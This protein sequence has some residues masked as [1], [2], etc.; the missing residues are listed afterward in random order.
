[1][2]I[3]SKNHANPSELQARLIEIAKYKS[4]LKKRSLKFHVINKQMK[5]KLTTSPIKSS[6]G[7]GEPDPE[8]LNLTFAKILERGN[9][10]DGD[11]MDLDSD[12]ATSTSSI[13]HPIRTSASL[14]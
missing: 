2:D 13:V 3:E 4:G 9:N 1:M 6:E 8:C 12:S 5:K 14:Q 11:T 7:D 10:D